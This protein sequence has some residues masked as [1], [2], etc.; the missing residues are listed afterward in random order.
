MK[1]LNSE[2]V[3][4][5]L[6][7]LDDLIDFKILVRQI[8]PNY[9]LDD[10]S[11]KKFLLILESLYQKLQPIFSSYLKVDLFESKKSPK[12]LK[13]MILEM[14]NDRQI[15]LITANS[16]KKKLKNIGVDPRNLIVSGG[17]LFLED[18]QI[19]NPN[20]SDEALE[21]IKK[22]CE[23]LLEQI[24]NE[25]WERKNLIFIYEKNNPTD[26]LILD[27]L[28]KISKLIGKEVQIFEIESWN[29]LDT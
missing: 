27:K 24:K 7:A 17:P 15:A 18:Y 22:K 10:T 20:L 14:I 2:E 25:D 29:I 19:V 28:E 12:E 11:Y 21:S 8:V 4:L 3:K 6:A 13:S 5:I 26:L 23:R 16:L 1:R 9:S